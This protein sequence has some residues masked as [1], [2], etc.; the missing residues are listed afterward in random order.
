[1]SLTCPHH[2]H[3]TS[4]MS[5]T[6]LQ[7]SYSHFLKELGWLLLSI[8]LK[9]EYCGDSIAC[10]KK[11]CWTPF[12]SFLKELVMMLKPPATG[13]G[14]SWRLMRGK[15]QKIWLFFH[16]KKMVKII[17]IFL[18]SDL[19]FFQIQGWGSDVV[20]RDLTQFCEIGRQRWV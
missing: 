6:N 12:L 15:F 16:E 18:L 14:R 5:L 2:H 10:Q 20:A 4:S 17:T 1:M 19:I 9:I 3:I 8:G 7:T 13:C 11:Q